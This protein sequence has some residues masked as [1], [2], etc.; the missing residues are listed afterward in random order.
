MRAKAAGEGLSTNAWV[1]KKLDDWLES[2]A[3]SKFNPYDLKL[4]DTGKGEGHSFRITK[5][6][7]D[8]IEKTVSSGLIPTTRII[9]ALLI[10]AL[11][12]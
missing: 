12:E 4:R 6:S 1:Q 7:K 11:V 8:D 10:R 9:R 2:M 5:S 3:N